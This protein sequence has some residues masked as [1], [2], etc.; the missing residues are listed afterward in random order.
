MHSSGFDIQNVLDCAVCNEILRNP[1][2]LTC[3][4]SFCKEC[5]DKIA[6]FTEDLILIKCPLCEKEEVVEGDLSNLKPPLILKQ[7]LDITNRYHNFL[8]L[9][10]ASKKLCVYCCYQ[11]EHYHRFT[12]DYFTKNFELIPNNVRKCLLL[13]LAS[14]ISK[15]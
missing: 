12:P 7:M 5:I 8:G 4:H 1:Q 14:N 6:K 11:N 10:E 3:E 13:L 15:I 9:V 2:T